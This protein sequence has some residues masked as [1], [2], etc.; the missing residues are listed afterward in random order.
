[1]HAASS[2]ASKVGVSCLLKTASLS[3]SE[4]SFSFSFLSDQSRSSAA[5]FETSSQKQLKE[6]DPQKR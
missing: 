4:N 2:V 6:H 1:M 5:L 3:P